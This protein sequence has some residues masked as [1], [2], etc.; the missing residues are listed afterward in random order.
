[1]DLLIMYLCLTSVLAHVA[2]MYL[3]GYHFA[4]K[5]ADQ[6]RED[7]HVETKLGRKL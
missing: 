4:D 2:V 7:N 1:M 5:W 6:H 3:I